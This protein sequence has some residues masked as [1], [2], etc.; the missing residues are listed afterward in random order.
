MKRNG[1]KSLSKEAQNLYNTLSRFADSECFL[2][3][4]A[5]PY[6]SCKNEMDELING[7]F[8][9]HF[10]NGYL[11]ITNENV[12]QYVLLTSVPAEMEAANEQIKIGEEEPSENTVNI[13]REF[14]KIYQAYPCSIGKSKKSSLNLYYGWLTGKRITVMGEKKTIKYNHIQIA[15]ALELF[16]EEKD[17]TEEQ[18][19]PRL[20]TFLGERL[21]CDY[22]TASRA[23]YQ[24]WMQ[25]RYGADW[26][27]VK[28]T[29]DRGSL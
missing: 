4:R 22:I 3:A 1:F 18:F 15:K 27:K 24:E 6:K 20:P 10:K 17:G 7:C 25:D 19:I 21:L 13:M 11:L 9:V 29:Y 28:F 16:I 2:K 5:F 14:A 26:A 8:L 12:R 23:A